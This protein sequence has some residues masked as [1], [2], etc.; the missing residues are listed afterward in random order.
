M[1]A[2]DT[3]AAAA[4]GATEVVQAAAK[5]VAYIAVVIGAALGIAALVRRFGRSLPPPAYLEKFADVADVDDEDQD[6]EEPE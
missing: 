5:P 2:T 4:E 6:D 1:T 3:A